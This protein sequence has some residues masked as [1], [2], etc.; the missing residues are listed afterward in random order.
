[1]STPY[2]AQIQIF[3][4]GFAPRYY[5]LCQGQIL[6]IN[7]NTALFALIGTTYGG[8][9]Q[10]TFALPDLRGRV[11]FQF[12][13][14][15]P[16]GSIGSGGDEALT[17]GIPQMPQHNHFLMTDST[18]TSGTTNAPNS[19][20]VLGSA[21]GAIVP[22]GS[23]TATIYGT[24]APTSALNNN[25]IGPQGASQPHSNLMPYLPINY[26]IALAG[27]FPSRP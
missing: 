10:T 9:G 23:F 20:E 24:R 18:T 17:L 6:P 19:L 13:P 7:Q 12:S 11:P 22:N 27:I 14:Q 3:A 26:S 5:A 1:M 4:F 25:A 2:L 15:Y 8:N 21:S 16:E